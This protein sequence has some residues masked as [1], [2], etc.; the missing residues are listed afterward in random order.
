[1]RTLEILYSI[2]R[3]DDLSD[4]DGMDESPCLDAQPV[5]FRDHEVKRVDE[6][7]RCVASKHRTS[8]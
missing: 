8:S 3:R 6:P 1:M 2:V 7:G 5:S 4:D